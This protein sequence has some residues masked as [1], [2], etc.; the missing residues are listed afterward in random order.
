MTC[1][2]E[3]GP[4]SQCFH[5]I[6]SSSTSWEPS[7]QHMGG[8]GGGER[9]VHTQT[10]TTTEDA[11]EGSWRT[12]VPTKYSQVNAKQTDFLVCLLLLFYFLFALLPFREAIPNVFS[13][14]IW[15][16]E[17]QLHTTYT[18]QNLDVTVMKCHQRTF[19]LNS[20]PLLS[21]FLPPS[22][23]KCKDYLKRES[24][25]K[26]NLPMSFLMIFYLLSNFPTALWKRMLSLF[27]IGECF[28]ETGFMRSISPFP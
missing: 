22:I 9:T 23:E 3:L 17:C 8:G 10:I 1:S 28:L 19:F 7:T 27:P 21:L 16:Y 2:L 4:N 26:G 24:Q 15:S 6:S 13:C 5:H 11:K 14:K 18:P 25:Y 12:P 20:P